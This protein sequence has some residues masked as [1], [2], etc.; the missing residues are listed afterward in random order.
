MKKSVSK[1]A[2]LR[3]AAFWDAMKKVAEKGPATL[4]HK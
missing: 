4:C 1:E 3:E 2:L